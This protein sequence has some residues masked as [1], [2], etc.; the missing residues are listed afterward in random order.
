MFGKIRFKWQVA[1]RIACA[2]ALLLLSFAHQPVTRANSAPFD[3]SSYLLPDGSLPILCFTAYGSKGGKFINNDPCQ[4]CRLAD[5]I[6]IPVA[7]AIAMRL[8][9]VIPVAHTIPQTIHFKLP[10]L[11]PAT[12]PRAPPA[13]V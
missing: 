1:W 5:S 3:L 11:Q 4:A 12:R 7:P 6:A 2:L 10:V 9:A 8:P 13:L